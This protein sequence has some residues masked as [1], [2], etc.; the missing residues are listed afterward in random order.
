M[1][2]DTCVWTPNRWISLTIGVTGSQ[3]P[4]LTI[5]NAELAKCRN[6][7]EF[8]AKRGTLCLRDFLTT[9]GL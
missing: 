7:A 1:R 3:S 8:N 5:D 4:Q 9:W 2:P 6:A